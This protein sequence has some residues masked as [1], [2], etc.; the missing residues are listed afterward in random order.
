[1]D[2]MQILQG[3]EKEM[4]ILFVH[5]TNN[6]HVLC[7]HRTS[8]HHDSQAPPNYEFKAIC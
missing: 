8:V 5:G 7:L 1:M 3:F 4:K 6:I 2:R